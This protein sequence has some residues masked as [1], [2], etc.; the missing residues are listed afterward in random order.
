M[1]LKK[2]IKA[3]GILMVK[4]RYGTFFSKSCEGMEVVYAKG[5]DGDPFALAVRA[6]MT[7]K[8]ERSPPSVED[9]LDRE[10][11]FQPTGGVPCVAW[12]AGYPG[13]PLQQRE[14]NRP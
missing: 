7:N 6:C 5:S 3:F 10:P 13:R 1:D 4:L 8:E 2:E 9:L 11:Y 14:F 12:V